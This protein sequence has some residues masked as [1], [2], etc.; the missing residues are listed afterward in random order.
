MSVL[1]KIRYAL[2]TKTK[3][4]V[5]K[6]FVKPHLVYCNTILDYARVDAI[7]NTQVVVNMGMRAILNVPLETRV[8]TML[9]NLNMLTIRDEVYLSTMVFIFKIINGLLPDYLADLVTKFREVHNHR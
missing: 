8:E 3:I 4:V 2:S 6:A 5:Y 9:L 1:R 7:R